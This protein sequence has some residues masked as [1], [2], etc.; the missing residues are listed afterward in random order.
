VDDVMRARSIWGLVL[1]TSV[2]LAGCGLP[3]GGGLEPSISINNATGDQWNGS[4]EVNA[5]FTV[6]LSHPSL[7][8]VTVDYDTVAGTAIEGTTYLANSGT[9][10]FDPGDTSEQIEVVVNDASFLSC[11]GTL[12]F[13]VELSNASGATIDDGEGAGTILDSFDCS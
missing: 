1:G 2:V 3:G 4:T 10:T 6:T 7:V 13:T 9:L 8:P 12:T 5:V 11:D